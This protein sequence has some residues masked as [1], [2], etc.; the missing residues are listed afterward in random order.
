MESLIDVTPGR[1]RRGV[2]SEVMPG[3]H[4]AVAGQ[5]LGGCADAGAAPMLS[6]AANDVSMLAAMGLHS[7]A[8]NDL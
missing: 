3:E 5:V 6:H 4:F 8:S 2:D 7:G 1:G